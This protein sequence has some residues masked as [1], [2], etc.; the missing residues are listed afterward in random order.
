MIVEIEDKIV[1]TDIFD[2]RFCC[3]LTVCKGICC[4]E[5]NAGAPLEAEEI[6]QL[7]EEFDRYKPY[8]KPE[9]VRA[10]ERQGFFVV[11]DDGD[12]TT[13]L[14][15]GGECAYVCEKDGVTFCAIE[16]AWHEGQTPF[17]KPIS[18][19]LYPI[20]LSRF[21][22]GTTGIMYHRWSICA[23]ALRLGKKVDQPLYRILREPLIRRFGE[24]FFRTLEEVEAT[25][26][27]TPR[28]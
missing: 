16:K 3:D 6:D 2:V 5:G 19:H 15:D 9:G 28:E 1:S 13:P 7:E 25:L 26:A 12:L 4:V 23:D 24:E 14:I 8:L 17:R 27:E 20:R 10:I 21:S 22:N 11:D 18:C